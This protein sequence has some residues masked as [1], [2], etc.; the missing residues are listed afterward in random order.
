[1]YKS[2]LYHTLTSYYIVEHYLQTYTEPS[3]ITMTASTSTS[4]IQTTSTSFVSTPLLNS[5]SNSNN[6]TTSNVD[7]VM[8]PLSKGCLTNNLGIPITI[9][10]CKVSFI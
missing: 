6:A 10:C 5:S 7:Q 4:S 9:V 2:D 8:L 1:M 3:N